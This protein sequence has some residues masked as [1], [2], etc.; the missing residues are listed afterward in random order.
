MANNIV[1]ISI[2][3]KGE[4]GI[5]K[6]LESVELINSNI[7]CLG[8]NCFDGCELLENI[9]LSPELV[10][11]DSECFNSC[12]NLETVSYSTYETDSAKSSNIKFGLGY[13]G[14]RAFKN[15]PGLLAVTLPESINSFSKINPRALE[16][17]SITSITMLGITSNQLVGT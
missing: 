9:Y 12:K 5:K 3:G 17:A 6:Q 10:K 13:I 4:N 16:G 8:A 11:I 14:A 2:A 1:K 15:C 7:S